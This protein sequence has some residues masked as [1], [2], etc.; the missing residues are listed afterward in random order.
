[1]KLRT[2]DCLTNIQEHNGV[3]ISA[4]L[5]CPCGC[6]TFSFQYK[7]KQTKGI[8]A[9]YIVKRNNQLVLKAICKHC[10]NS[11]VLYDS[12]KDGSSPKTCIDETNFVPLVLPKSGQD[13]YKVI[14]KY[15]YLLEKMKFENQYSNR[16]ENCF[17]YVLDQNGKEKALIEE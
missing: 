7:G 1:M 6:D 4:D 17:I 15:N 10:E 12:S 2:L 3:A 8:L 13:F 16:F 9:P 11:F 5:K 14:V